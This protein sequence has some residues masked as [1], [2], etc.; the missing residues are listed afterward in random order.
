MNIFSSLAFPMRKSFL[1]SKIKTPNHIQKII[2]SIDNIKKNLLEVDGWI[3][4]QENCGV[5]D[6]DSLGKIYQIESSIAEVLANEILDLSKDYVLDNEK[7]D[8]LKL[9][10]NRN[11][12]FR[13]YS[14]LKDKEYKNYLSIFKKIL[15]KG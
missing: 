14:Y 9:I 6:K 1:E 8:Y 13:W 12:I 11:I 15:N 4:F 10:L 5:N 3:S 2:S 7:L